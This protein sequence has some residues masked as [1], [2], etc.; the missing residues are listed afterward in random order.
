MAAT[1]WWSFGRDRRLLA[2]IRKELEDRRIFI[3]DIWSDPDLNR[4]LTAFSGEHTLVAHCAL[5]LVEIILPSIDLRRH[6]GTHPRT[7][8]LDWVRFSPLTDEVSGA[9]ALEVFGSHMSAYYQ[10]PIFSDGPHSDAA[11]ER[12]IL[13]LR[14][15]GFGKMHDRALEPDFGPPVAHEQYGVTMVYVGPHQLTASLELD[16][17]TA[18]AAEQVAE[19]LQT[20][21][22]EG[23]PLLYGVHAEGFAQ[24]TRDGSLLMLTFEMANEAYPDQVLKIAEKEARLAG[25]AAGKARALGVWRTS[26]LGK[27]TRLVLDEER[28][29]WDDVFI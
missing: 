9:G 17:P 28:Q 13:E 14:E 16:D 4:T 2:E 7:G 3:I 21:R 11:S 23:D 12:R 6:T 5:E 8:A 18:K 29:V 19:E 15:G 1:M 27:A 10:I 24:P 22:F 26:D 25:A 20:L